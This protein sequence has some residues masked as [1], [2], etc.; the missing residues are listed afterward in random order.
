MPNR[1][2]SDE[3]I[4]QARRAL[5][6]TAVRQ[7]LARR[8]DEARCRPE[9]LLLLDA[10]FTRLGL[11]DPERHIRVAIARY[12][13]DAIV[14][15][16][17]IF[18]GKR[19]AQT[20]PD[21]VDARYL[22]GIVRNIAAQAE[23]EHIARRLFELRLEVR[24]QIFQQDRFTGD[25]DGANLQ[26]LLSISLS[27]CFFFPISS[28]PL[29][30]LNVTFDR[31]RIGIAIVGSLACCAAAITRSA[32]PINFFSTAPFLVSFVFAM[33]DP[34]CAFVVGEPCDRRGLS[35]LA[36]CRM[37]ASLKPMEHVW[38]T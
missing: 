4:E 6:E 19:L 13:L 11:L 25:R 23:G 5:R 17:A 3:Q 32:R 10:H 21:G 9:V 26:N 20:L 34:M 18:E 38:P 31:A 14:D 29:R 2:L 28:R 37:Y 8:T 35:Q 16:I 33:R 24:D 22:L 1:I 30:S 7:E 15:G 36:S 27:A 12:P